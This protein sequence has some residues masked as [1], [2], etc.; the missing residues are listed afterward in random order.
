MATKKLWTPPLKVV[1]QE[2]EASH[3]IVL[4]LCARNGLSGLNNFEFATGLKLSHVFAGRHTNRLAE[5]LHM[6]TEEVSQ[7]AYQV[8]STK[9]ILV[10]GEELR[11]FDISRGHRRVRP[12]CLKENNYQQFWWDLL[13]MTH[14]PIHGVEL[15]GKCPCGNKL[16]WK[17]REIVRCRQ[18]NIGSVLE[19]VPICVEGPQ[20]FQRWA[21][22]RFGVIEQEQKVPMLDELPLKDAIALCDRIGRL[23]DK[24]WCEFW[25]DSSVTTDELTRSRESGFA[26]IRDS[27]LLELF[28]RVH[29][30]S[31]EANDSAPTSMEAS[32][33]WFW[34]WFTSV[35]GQDFSKQLS[36]VLT[37]HFDGRFYFKNPRIKLDAMP[38]SLISLDQLAHR[39]GTAPS[40]LRAALIKSG[41]LKP[42]K[43]GVPL[44]ITEKAAA[45]ILEN[46][47]DT[48]EV[49]EAQK[50]VGV[51]W[52]TWELLL[53]RGWLPKFMDSV[54]YSSRNSK[55]IPFIRRK[56]VTDWVD[57]LAGDAPILAACSVGHST[58]SGPNR[59]KNVAFEQLF[60]RVL[61]K[62]VPV[63]GRLEEHSGLAGLVIQNDD[64]DDIVFRG[65]GRYRSRDKH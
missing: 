9:P 58:I 65:G 27:L 16:T 19:T 49:R 6:P 14:C 51:G 22:G 63:V 1:P 15:V 47:M 45:W 37:L 11:K 46:F 5:I 26:I 50:L 44:Q 62:S 18:C 59:N 35:G 38:K 3:G 28:D 52:R 30:Q 42:A 4:R 40:I 41:R 54:R 12:C 7:R 48:M 61:D 8:Q 33:G 36:V 34:I 29:R 13:F 25:H 39:A 55:S 32:L 2:W 21:L 57:A 43:Q 53:D 20:Q 17:D 10:R 23:D 24:G 64:I 31:E 56:A 60:E